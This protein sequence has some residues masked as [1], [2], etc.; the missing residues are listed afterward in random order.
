MAKSMEE[1]FGPI[2]KVRY[3]PGTR[4]R[5]EAIVRYVSFDKSQDPRDLYHA[6]V[7]QNRPLIVTRGGVLL[8]HHFI[9]TIP[10]ATSFYPL[11]TN[12]DEMWPRQ[13]E[14][15]AAELGLL[16]ARIAGPEFIVS[17]GR[18]YPLAECVVEQR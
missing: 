17:D 9:V 3:L 18:S 2:G 7:T 4:P 5:E 11:V 6:V 14:L 12:R 8:D 10:D 15:G 16:T 1:I 13:I